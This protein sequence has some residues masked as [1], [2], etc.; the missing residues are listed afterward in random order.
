MKVVDA[1]ADLLDR[2]GN[3]VAKDRRKLTAPGARHVMDIALAD[4][5]RADLDPDLAA[6]YLVQRNLFDVKRL[7]EV[8]TDGGLHSAD[9]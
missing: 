1:L 5:A 9:S 2:A 4:A 8:A 7:S 3:L 6:V